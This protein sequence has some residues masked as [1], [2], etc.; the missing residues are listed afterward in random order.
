MMEDTDAQ[1]R[2]FFQCGLKIDTTKQGHMFLF[3]LRKKPSRRRY[4][5]WYI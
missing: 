1:R 4:L 3:F 2:V 5:V